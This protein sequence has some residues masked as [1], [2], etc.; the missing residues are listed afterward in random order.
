MLMTTQCRIA[1]VDKCPIFVLGIDLA[2]RHDN[3]LLMVAH[4]STTSDLER[5]VCEIP[6]DVLVLDDTIAGSQLAIMSDHARSTVLKVIYFA[7]V[8]SW[9]CAVA[10]SR[11]SARGYITRRTTGPELI[12]TILA[13]HNGQRYIAPELAWHLT[14]VRTKV[15]ETEQLSKRE[16]QVFELTAKGFSNWE[17]AKLLNLGF[18]TVKLYK[19]NIYRKLGVRNRLEA[20]AAMQTIRP[21]G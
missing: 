13:V 3:R 12:R 18:S 21:M 11:A 19:T 17:V 14:T 1:V 5:I 9:D 7:S 10:P 8:V 15:S 20:I 4:G 6:L 16:Q 2:I